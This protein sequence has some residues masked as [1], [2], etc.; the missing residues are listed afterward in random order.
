MIIFNAVMRHI[1][2]KWR[3]EPIWAITDASLFKLQ[4]FNATLLRIFSLDC[5]YGHF[6][7]PLS[8]YLTRLES[9]SFYFLH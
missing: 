4:F 3:R 8:T 2:R 7:Y 5:V 9:C 6:S 1:T